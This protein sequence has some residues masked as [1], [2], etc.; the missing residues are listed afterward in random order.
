MKSLAKTL[1]GLALILAWW[2]LRGPGESSGASADHIPK[3]V[4]DGGAGQLTIRTETSCPAQM[5]VSFN[6]HSENPDSRSLETY[7]DVPAG[8]HSWTIDVPSDVGGYVELS[9]TSP[10]PGDRLRWTIEAAGTTVDEQADTL[11][12]PLEEGYGFFLQSYFD[13]YATGALGE[14]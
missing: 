3:V 5:R 6:E 13:D 9:A 11:E 10:H 2:T 4:W 1:I 7:E 8:S 14:G 12:K